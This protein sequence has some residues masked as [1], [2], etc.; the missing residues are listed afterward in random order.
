MY[1][2]EKMRSTR[3]QKGEHIDSFLSKLQ[4]LEDQLVLVGSSPQPIEMVRFALNSVSEEWKVFV[5]SILGREKFLDWKGCGP[6]FS[7]KR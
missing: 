5:Q 2:E 1:L 3:M 4:E 7:R 6:L